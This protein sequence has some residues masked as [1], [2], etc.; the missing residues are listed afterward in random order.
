MKH[1]AVL[2]AFPACAAGPVRSQ[3]A[4]DPPG[5]I[6]VTIASFTVPAWHPFV[7]VASFAIKRP[8]SQTRS[9]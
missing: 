2:V 1:V 9:P 7:P 4:G 3:D 8:A 6:S 5:H